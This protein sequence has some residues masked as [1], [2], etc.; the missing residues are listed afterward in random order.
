[1]TKIEI[2]LWCL[3]AYLACRTM[4]YALALTSLLGKYRRAVDAGRM[5]LRMQ[6]PKM[7]FMLIV[8]SAALWFTTITALE[9]L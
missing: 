6:M 1:M 2:V 8:F 5:R 9:V 4:D 3:L 7:I